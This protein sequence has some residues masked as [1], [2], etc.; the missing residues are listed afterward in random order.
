[1]F[2]VILVCLLVGK[3]S[4]QETNLPTMEVA[5]AVIVTAKLDLDQKPPTITEALG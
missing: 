5:Q 1:M 4:A 3:A 2:R